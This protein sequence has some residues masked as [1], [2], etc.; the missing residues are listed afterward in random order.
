MCKNIV[1]IAVGGLIVITQAAG[2]GKKRLQQ[3][4]PWVLTQVCQWH[5]W[6]MAVDHIQNFIFTESVLTQQR[7]RRLKLKYLGECA[8]VFENILGYENLSPKVIC[9]MK[10]QEF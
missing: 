4:Y 8:T 1:L 9:L 6:V 10:K 7:H 3:L 2:S 5:C